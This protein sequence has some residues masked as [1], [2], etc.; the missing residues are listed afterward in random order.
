MLY[1]DFKDKK[2]SMLGLGCMR[3]PVVD[4]NNGEIDKLKAAEMISYALK[5]GVNYF[6][7]AW[8]YHEG[9]SEPVLGELMGKHPRESYYLASK[10]PGYDLS[11]MGKV[12]EI[13]E[14]Q[15]K[16]CCVDYFDFY[17]FHNVCELNINAYLD[18]NNGILRY[19]LKQKER[20]KIKHLGFS[21]HG[22]MEILK[23]FLGAYGEHMEF[24][25]LQVNY[26]DWKYQKAEEKVR[27]VAEAGLPI[28]VMEPLRGGRLVDIKEKDELVKLRPKESVPAWAFRF[29][30][31]LPE[32]TV[33]LS[34][35]SDMEQLK[36]NIETFSI[37]APLNDYEMNKLLDIATRIV[38][39]VPCTK[40]RYCTSKCPKKLDIPWLISLYNEHVFTDKGFYAP[41]T[42]SSMS[43]E[44][45]PDCCIG[46]GNC[47]KVCPQGI[48]ISEIMKDFVNML[49][50]EE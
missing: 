38:N 3:L 34:G 8:G 41:M 17:L 15:L 49:G 16:R 12:E 40:C 13:F 14:A 44:E 19:L 42:L 33:V 43:R 2:I 22:S 31:T 6:D 36:E 7:T 9:T 5:N 18:E 46:C 30:Q 47:E 23:R 28:W 35:M 29:L 1:K 21:S 4:G 48:K 11:N 37:N 26:L 50:T 27:F 20:G 25:Q 24:C 45:Q 39:G 32:V 10:F